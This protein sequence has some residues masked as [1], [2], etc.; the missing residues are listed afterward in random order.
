MS[1]TLIQQIY[2]CL[3][4]WYMAG[5]NM[6]LLS[7]DSPPEMSNLLKHDQNRSNAREQI[8]LYSNRCCSLLAIMVMKMTV[9]VVVVMLAMMMVDPSIQSMAFE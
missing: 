6:A 5:G 2:H 3:C 7:D 1:H 9:L 4:N 8:Q